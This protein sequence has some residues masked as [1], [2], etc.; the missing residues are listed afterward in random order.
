MGEGVGGA[1]L[2]E[3]G[4]AVKLFYGVE[5]GFRYD[6][7]DGLS[8]ETLMNKRA[9]ASFANFS[10]PLVPECIFSLPLLYEN[11]FFGVGS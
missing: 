10:C 8:N 4:W 9:A 7:F 6:T 5:L 11:V 2:E 1:L 3:I